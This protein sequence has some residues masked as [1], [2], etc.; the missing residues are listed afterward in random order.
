MHALAGAVVAA[1]LIAVSPA[2]AQTAATPPAATELDVCKT[3]LAPSI[4]PAEE[5]ATNN[6][7]K[8]KKRLLAYQSSKYEEDIAKV[9]ESVEKFVKRRVAENRRLPVDQ[10]KRFAIV[11]DIDETSL[12]NWENI[13]ANNFGFIESGPCFLE[14]GLAC[15]FKEWINMAS[16]KAIKPTRRLFELARSNDIAV[17]F[18]TGRRDSQRLATMANLDREGFEGWAALRARPDGQHGSIV[19]FKS[20]E[21]AKLVT[22]G[23]YTILANIGDQ[24]TDLVDGGGKDRDKLV[25]CSVKLPNP[26][27]F[28]D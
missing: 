9:I 5:P 16:A 23:K 20:S 1:V 22:D 2:A 26:F 21:R 19:P 18:I 28:I 11:L 13:K 24:E 27:Y 7:D 17:F 3:D 12:S 14:T 8:L 6:I 25:E 10:M 15:G 4:P